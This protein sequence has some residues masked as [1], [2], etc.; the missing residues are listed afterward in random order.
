MRD[1]PRAFAC[2]A[3]SGKGGGVNDTFAAAYHDRHCHRGDGLYESDRI[4][5]VSGR[6]KDA[7]V[8]SVSRESAPTG[9]VRYA[10]DLLPQG[11]QSVFTDTCFAGAV[12]D[13]ADHGR[14]R[15]EAQYVPVDRVGN[16]MLY[17]AY[18]FC[19]LDFRMEKCV[20]LREVVKF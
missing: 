20:R 7:A 13:R 6:E 8:Y 15:L 9:G 17:V 10:R 11:Q 18:V 14:S 3:S 19:V 1:L 5:A 16:R 12:I 2:K 4:L